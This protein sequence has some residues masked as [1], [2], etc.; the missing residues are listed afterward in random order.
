MDLRFAGTVLGV[1]DFETSAD[2]VE[3]RI[4]PEA[5]RER[6]PGVVGT[7]GEGKTV[8]AGCELSFTVD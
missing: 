1:S 8:E 2:G 6:G 4:G 3:G 7:E 5:T